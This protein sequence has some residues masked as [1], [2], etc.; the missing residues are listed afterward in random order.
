MAEIDGARVM[1]ERV[2]AGRIFSVVVSEDRKTAKLYEECDRYFHETVTKDEL[3]QLGRE[4]IH[5]SRDME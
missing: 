2:D 3:A 4:L 1:L 5:L